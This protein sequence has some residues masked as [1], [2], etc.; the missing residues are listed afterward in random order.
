MGGIN[1]PQAP[2]EVLVELSVLNCSDRRGEK[3]KLTKA[4]T[5]SL[6][7]SVVSFIKR[8]TGVA[9][10]LTERKKH[11][12]KQAL[13]ETHHTGGGRAKQEQSQVTRITVTEE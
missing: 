13:K 12:T 10:Q 11:I 4:P 7:H 9:K 3:V 1:P 2:I 6:H 8:D 5:Q